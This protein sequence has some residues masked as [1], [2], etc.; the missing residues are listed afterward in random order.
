LY[1]ID[2]LNGGSIYKYTSNNPNAADGNGYFASGQTF[3]A[4]VNGGNNADAVGNVVWTPITDINGGA[5]VG[6]STVNTDGTIDGRITADT[7][8]ATNYQRPEDVEIALNSFGHEVLY[9]PT[10]TTNQVFAFNLTT[11]T[12]SVFADANTINLAT[13]LA[14]GSAAF[15]S[16]DN[17]AVDAEGNIY[18]VEDR[19]G[20]VDNDI[21]FAKDLNK[22]GDLLDAGEGVARWASNGTPG[23][24]FTG[25]YFDKTNP[26]VAFVNIQHPTTGDDSLIRLTAAVPEPSTYLMMLLGLAGVGFLA[27][28]R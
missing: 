26:N 4:K 7:V 27:R 22:D 1:F 19:N 15:T 20:A 9:I 23:S 13:G 10:T 11:N 8:Q 6:T 14:V 24:E 28:R 21:W 25:L 3:A 18:I 5:I 2:E 12:A 16:P 17:V